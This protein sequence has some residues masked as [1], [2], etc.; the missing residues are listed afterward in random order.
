M[1]LQDSYRTFPRTLRG[2]PEG[3]Q[4]LFKPV[5]RWK[6]AGIRC[7]VGFGTFFP[8]QGVWGKFVLTDQPVDVEGVHCV[9]YRLFQGVQVSFLTERYWALWVTTVCTPNPQLLFR[10]QKQCSLDFG[11]SYSWTAGDSVFWA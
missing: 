1:G 6:G 9:L 3:L 10:A 5:F 7:F 4:A 2:T 11:L 8:A